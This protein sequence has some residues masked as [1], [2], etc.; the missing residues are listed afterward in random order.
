MKIFLLPDYIVGGH[1]FCNGDS[2]IGRLDWRIKISVEPIKLIT[3]IHIYTTQKGAAERNMEEFHNA[4][5]SH[6]NHELHGTHDAH[7]ILVNPQKLSQ[8]LTRT[9]E[10]ISIIF[11]SLGSKLDV[12]DLNGHV[13]QTT[14][15]TDEA[16]TVTA[17]A[18]QGT[19][20]AT[21]SQP[22]QS[23]QSTQTETAEHVHSPEPATASKS[24]EQA[25]QAGSAEQSKSSITLDDITKVI[26][27]KI[28][29]D[30][31][32][33]ERIGTIVHN[34]GVPAI[35]YLPES[36]YETFLAEIASLGSFDFEEE[37]DKDADH[38]NNDDDDDDNDDDDD[39]PYDY[40]DN[41]YHDYSDDDDDDDDDET[42]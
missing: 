32:N 14:H 40:N 29:Q 13:T 27:E 24:G 30:R 25:E 1:V 16:G 33:N 8:G 26:V 5:E 17:T 9:F 39:E 19:A 38:S 2:F 22:A 37:N 41:D 23:A 18:K 34:Y 4:H 42:A 28:K 15:V 36:K 12:T 7:S 31:K 21:K 6:D 35:S 10:G 3:I 20:E 11:A